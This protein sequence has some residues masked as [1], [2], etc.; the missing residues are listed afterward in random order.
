MHAKK[1]VGAG[2]DY[3]V[4]IAQLRHWQH[5]QMQFATGIAFGLRIE[6]V[7]LWM[8]AAD[9]HCQAL[10]GRHLDKLIDRN[11]AS[12]LLANRQQQTR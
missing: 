12:E 5:V 10:H 9:Q 6:A 1:T 3:L 2:D 4:H 11:G 8:L 7:S